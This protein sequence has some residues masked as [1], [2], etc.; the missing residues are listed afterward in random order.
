MDFG[1][2]AEQEAL[3]TTVREFVR[4]RI[5]PVAHE[6]EASGR[7]PTEIVDEM[8]AMGLFG[9]LVPEEYGGSAI[10]LVSYAIVFEEISRGWMGVAGT[11]GSH[12][13][14]TALLARFGTADQKRRWLP[15]LATGARRSGFALTEPGAGTDLQGISTV[16]RRVGDHYIVSGVKTWITNARYAD[17]LPILVKTDPSATPPSRGMSILYVEGGTPGLEIGRDLGKL[18]YRGTESC[19]VVFAD[20]RVPAENLLGGQEGAG[21]KQALSVLEIGRINIAARAVGVAQAAYEA[22][23]AYAQQRRAFGHPIADF[24]AVQLKIADMATDIQA[25]RL[26]T[27][28]AADRVGSQPRADTESGMA[29]Y[30]A[31]EVALRAALAAMRIH[32][33][34]GYSTEFDV[35]R[36]YR[37]APLMAIGEGTNDVLRVVI[38][39]NLLREHA[40]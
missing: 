30:F 1:L 22:A 38:A 32:G 27:W 5:S 24:Q 12:S 6:W 25:A 35:E 3:R 37:D 39:R 10:D 8:K 7:Y 36:Y 18:G 28:W 9:M 21:M 13:L 19:E 26:L 2:N 33:A 40:V 34:Y 15:Q 20:A 31:S 14:S 11:L 17:P 29:K 16:A 23:L 4:A